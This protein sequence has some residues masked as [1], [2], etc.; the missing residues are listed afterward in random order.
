MGKGLKVTVTVN[1][2][3]HPNPK[4]AIE[5]VAGLIVKELVDN[6]EVP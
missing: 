5:L 4:E 1:V 2:I 6:K 3:S